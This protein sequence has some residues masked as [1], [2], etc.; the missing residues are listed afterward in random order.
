MQNFIVKSLLVVVLS[1][2]GTKEKHP[3]F[4]S[5]TELEYNAKE[6]LLEISCKI[7]TDDFEKTLR[8]VYN[9]KVDLV[10][11]AKK[12]AMD[13]LVNDYIKKHLSVQVDKKET[14]LKY[15]G[16]EIIEEAVFCY[17]EIDDII[18][19]KKITISN[20]L[21]FDYKKEQISIMHVSVNG[22]RQ[23]AK[24]S[25]PEKIATFNF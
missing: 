24:L 11:V 23:S 13:K 5:V 22:K 17:F 15:V 9:T 18:N 16:F 20:N 7:F 14:T 25:N 2:F 6:K 10:D 21:L 12:T 19:P 4:M 8:I 3:I 1:F